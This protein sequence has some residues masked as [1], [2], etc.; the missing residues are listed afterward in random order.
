MN[1]LVKVSLPDPSRRHGGRVWPRETTSIDGALVSMLVADFQ[2]A[3]IVENEGFLRFLKAID[4]RYQ[5]PSRRTLMRD[6][7]PQLYEEKVAELKE[8]L[9][10]IEHCTL[11]TDLWTSNQTMGYLTVTCHFISQSWE[12]ESYVLET[13]HVDQAHTIENLASVSLINGI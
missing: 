13:T 4:Q 12:I 6:H 10:S 9:V 11:T 8:K 7:L 2:P 1:N 3:S 5:P